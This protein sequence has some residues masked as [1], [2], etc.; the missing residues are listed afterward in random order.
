MTNAEIAAV[1]ERIALVLDLKGG[2]NPFRIRAYERAA[3]TIGNLSNDLRSI[4]GDGGLDA[5]EEVPG[6]GKDLTLMIAGQNQK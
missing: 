3:M 5:L 1:F 2:E 6:I 4:Y